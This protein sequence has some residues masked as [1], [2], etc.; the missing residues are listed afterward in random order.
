[1][2][3]LKVKKKRKRRLR[4]FYKHG[5]R[6]L[7]T[8]CFSYLNFMSKWLSSTNAKEIGTLYLVFSV[9]AGMI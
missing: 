2:Y 4:L 1:M 9:F 5:K 8:I 7:V 6:Q 3:A